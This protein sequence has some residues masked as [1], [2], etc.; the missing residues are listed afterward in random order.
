[1]NNIS[2]NRPALNEDGSVKNN[3]AS[4]LE[5][6]VVWLGCSALLVGGMFGCRSLMEY[7]ERTKDYTVMNYVL[8]A[9]LA[10]CV[11]ISILLVRLIKRAKETM[12]HEVMLELKADVSASI[13]DVVPAVIGPIWNGEYALSVNYHDRNKATLSVFVNNKSPEVLGSIM[14]A[15]REN[16]IS[17]TRNQSGRDKDFAPEY[18]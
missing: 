11:F 9:M 3:G 10:A 4:L 13:L 16:G 1:M 8:V 15:I 12:N 2:Y 7:T 5:C 14:K 6:L 18:R 17:V